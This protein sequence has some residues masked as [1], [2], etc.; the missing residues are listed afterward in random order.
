MPL[1]L[2]AFVAEEYLDSEYLLDEF[3]SS[4]IRDEFHDFLEGENR[5]IVSGGC[6]NVQQ[7]SMKSMLKLTVPVNSV[8]D[9]KLNNFYHDDFEFNEKIFN[10]GLSFRISDFAS[11]G[12]L[13]NP[14]FYKKESDISIVA[15]I[16][17]FNTKNQITFTF[18]NFDNNY[19]HKDW[20]EHLPEPRIYEKQPYT[21]NLESTGKLK[22]L[23]FYTLFKRRFLSSEERF[24]LDEE[25]DSFIYD[26]TAD[27]ALMQVV[28]GYRYSKKISSLLF[29]GGAAFSALVM[30]NGYS[31][32]SEISREDDRRF[33]LSAYL[34]GKKNSVTGEVF[35]EYSRR[36]IESMYEKESWLAGAGVLYSWRF[37]DISLKQ[38]FSQLNS[39]MLSDSLTKESP[40]SRLLLTLTYKIS[41]NAHFT[42]RKGFETDKRDIENGGKYFFYDKAYVLFYM[43][44]D[45]FLTRGRRG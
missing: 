42:A 4:Y 41:E 10:F 7:L 21:L 26:Y 25:A 38:F 6:Y 17:G 31:D 14:T 22:E 29:E 11:I 19:S 24:H 44:F 27:S 23:A 34:T 30:E 36:A 13:A 43:N 5:V 45:N 28:T 15:S 3:S 9:F 33:K 39:I 2:S 8:V 12:F 16:S 40:Q 1:V 32:S 18:D 37:V 20:N 35:G